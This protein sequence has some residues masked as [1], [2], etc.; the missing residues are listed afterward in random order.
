MIVE[1]VMYMKNKTKILKFHHPNSS[2]LRN[3]GKNFHFVT[4][5]LN[6]TSLGKSQ[7]SNRVLN[8]R[9][10]KA[11]IWVSAI[12]Y[13]LVAV[14]A[15]TLILNT[16]M[17]ILSE[18]KDRSVYE[19]VKNIMLD[20]DEH[21]TEIANQGEGSQASV[22]FDIKDGKVKFENNEIIWEIETK[23][24]I[25]SPR[26]STKLGNLIIS[27]NANV[28]TYDLTNFHVME[29]NIKN[30]TLSIAIN[31][32][33]SASNWVN[34]NT[35]GLIQNISYNG[36][37]MNGNFTFNLNN[38][39]SSAVGNGYTYMKPN[40]NNS[41]LGSAEV[42][43][44]LNTSFAEYDLVFRLESYADFLIVNVKNLVIK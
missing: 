15:L 5:F 14:L 29:T 35:S 34:L 23:T 7:Q 39:A 3:I 8:Q 20:L 27:S 16:G 28:R 26:S 33:G 9:S 32:K 42:I 4:R 2:K 25:I 37:N 18:F 31:K 19:K 17:P 21:I 11:Q 41:N 40:G 13:T 10:N 22:S 12:I 43:A 38:N 44:H 6:I 1:K 24:E 36:N 30:D